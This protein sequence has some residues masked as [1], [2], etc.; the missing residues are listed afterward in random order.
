MSASTPPTP[1]GQD[2]AAL[3]SQGQSEAMN[4][5]VPRATQHEDES[6]TAKHRDV[7]TAMNQDV[8]RAV[9]E[10]E[11]VPAATSPGASD[12]A[13]G[14]PL[15]PGHIV[16]GDQPVRLFAGQQIL[17]VTVRNTGDRAVQVGSHYHFAQSNPALEFDR[18][19]ALGHRLAIP[20]G[21]SV[22]FEPGVVRTVALVPLRGRGAVP[23]LRRDLAAP[24]TP[25]PSD[26]GSAPRRPLAAT[27]TEPTP[28]QDGA[29]G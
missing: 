1:T 21:T 18:D 9:P 20:A 25:S 5:D 14:W 28:P 19:R 17:E 13:A 16:V 10:D 29:D 12:P 8:A 7:P 3:A 23:G 22:R 6:D 4:R 2:R 15:I 11:D 26:L 24:P 27:V